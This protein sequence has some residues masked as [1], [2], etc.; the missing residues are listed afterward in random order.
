MSHF[1]HTSTLPL[2]RSCA[3]LHQSLVKFS[4]RRKYENDL[5]VRTK[6]RTKA[7]LFRLLLTNDI[8][9]AFFTRRFTKRRFMPSHCRAS[10][11]HS[12]RIPNGK[13]ES[14]NLRLHS[15]DWSRRGPLP[16]ELFSGCGGA[17]FLQKQGEK[18]KL[19]GPAGAPENTRVQLKTVSAPESPMKRTF[20][21]TSAKD[22]PNFFLNFRNN[23][24]FSF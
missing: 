1:P 19:S 6:F 18:K 11:M 24:D 22:P 12:G 10:G 8:I 4:I 13:E 21:K 5:V 14:R 15:E 2:A 20:D 23:T 9:F 7:I 17:E 3:E 16:K